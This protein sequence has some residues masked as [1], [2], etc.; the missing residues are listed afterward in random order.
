[1]VFQSYALFPHMTRAGER[2][3]TASTCRACA[4]AEAPTSG[5]RGARNASGS[6]GF[7]AAPAVRALGR[8]AA[9]RGASRARWCSSRRC[10]CSTSRCR[11]STRG[12][13]G[14]CARRSASCSSGSALTVVYVTHD[15]AEAMAVSD[16]IIVM[17][18]GGDRAGGRAARAV[19][20]A[21]RR[22]SSPAS[23][24]TRTACAACSRVA[25][26]RVADVAIGPLRSRCRIAALPTAKSTS[27]SA[28]RRSSFGARR[29]APLA[30]HGAQGRLP[31]R[32]DGVHARHRRSASSSSS[33]RAVERAA[34]R[35]QRGAVGRQRMAMR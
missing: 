5:A 3:A 24:A 13:A 15:Q 4:K 10:C 12:C 17:N 18:N 19:R 30:R 11:T 29:S 20:A 8:P 6:T 9:A 2:R 27:R 35:R 21:A 26:M 23:W 1:M 14:R 16:R 33:S 22:R 28:P 31:R 25:T 32:R 34:C 7:D